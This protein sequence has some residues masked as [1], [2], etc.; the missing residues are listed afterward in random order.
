MCLS[1]LK[2]CFKCGEQMP[3]TEF[4]PHPAMA[5]GLLGKCKFCTKMD[6]RKRRWSNREAVLAYDSERA[7]QPQRR[8]AG[9]LSQKKRRAAFPE[10]RRANQAV[11]RA[12]LNGGLK[13]SPCAVCG[14]AKVEAHHE[15]Y[16]LPLAVIWLCGPCHKAHHV[17]LRLVENF[18]ESVREPFDRCQHIAVAQRK[19]AKE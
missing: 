10:K 18:R 9:L 8:E 5:D 19:E 14:S 4:Y 12:L 15:D 7:Q 16:S 6:T 2:K 13:K 1:D 3:R 11:L 17:H